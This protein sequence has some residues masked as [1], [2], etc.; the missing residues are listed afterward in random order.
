MKP[1]LGRWVLFY[2]MFL[3]A[4]GIAGFASNPEKAKTALISGGTFG[5]LSM[6]WGWLM[7]RGVAWSRWAAIGTTTLLTGVFIWRAS[8]SW[9]AV[10]D[11]IADKRTAALL[12]TAMGTAS[13]GTLVVLLSSTG[14]KARI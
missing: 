9:M 8:V 10:A 4:M 6:L 7:T 5:G 2:G 11:G 3:I 13:I 12:I 14:Q 1:H